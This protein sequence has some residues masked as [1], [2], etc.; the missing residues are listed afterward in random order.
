MREKGQAIHRLKPRRL[1][2]LPERT[3]HRLWLFTDADAD[4]GYSQFYD[5]INTILIGR[6]TYDQSLEF[7]T[8]TRTRAKQEGVYVFTQNAEFVSSDVPEFVRKLIRS[9]GRD[10]WLVGGADI[11]SI[12]LNAGLVDE[13]ILSIHPIIL[14]SGI[15]PLFKDIQ[16]R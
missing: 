16:G 9:Q 5:S 15:I 2:T 11:I 1:H 12:L 6:K 7:V 3:G 14:G 8:N 13:I 4:Y 10:I